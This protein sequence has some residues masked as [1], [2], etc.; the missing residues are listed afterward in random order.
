MPRK[1]RPRTQRG[2][3]PFPPEGAE[4][5]RAG[6]TAFPAR[7]VF[8]VTPEVFDSARLLRQ[9]PIWLALSAAGLA[10][11]AFAARAFVGVAFA[12]FV[13]AEAVFVAGGAVPEPSLSRWAPAFLAAVLLRR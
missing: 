10:E 6:D 4:P 13:E 1:P 9:N 7:A 5:G 2:Q 11:A 8:D 12:T 3:S